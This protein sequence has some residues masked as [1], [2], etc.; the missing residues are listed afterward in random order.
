MMANTVAD[1]PELRWGR[2]VEERVVGSRDIVQS[3]TIV[4]RRTRL[5]RVSDV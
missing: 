1:I 5:V 4:R 3:R 2:M